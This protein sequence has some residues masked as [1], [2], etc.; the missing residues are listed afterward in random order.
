L[1]GNSNYAIINSQFCGVFNKKR[2]DKMGG[3]TVDMFPSLSATTRS[4]RYFD[5]AFRPGDSSSKFS[6]RNKFKCLRFQTI[7][8]RF[9]HLRMDEVVG[10]YDDAARILQEDPPGGRSGIDLL[11]HGQLTTRK[12]AVFGVVAFN[13]HLARNGIGWRIGLGDILC[14]VYRIKYIRHILCGL[15]ALHDKVLAADLEHAENLPVG[16]EL[17]ELCRRLNSFKTIRDICAAAGKDA[18]NHNLLTEELLLQILF[19]YDTTFPTAQ[20]LL[21]S[22][23]KHPACAKHLHELSYDSIIYEVEPYKKRCAE[24]VTAENVSIPVDYSNNPYAWD[25]LRDRSGMTGTVTGLGSRE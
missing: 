3:D 6:Q 19:E 22:L 1:C 11:R 5:T 7:A 9:R 16:H 15:I 8:D 24:S 2:W 12:K 4:E 18:T 21:E 10:L 13:L 23:S 25:F 20:A 14:S 17:S